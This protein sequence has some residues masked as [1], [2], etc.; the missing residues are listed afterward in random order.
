M[1]LW[2][3]VDSDEM[4]N[5]IEFLSNWRWFNHCKSSRSLA[6]HFW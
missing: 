4:I 1:K 6:L 3:T 5:R 2:F